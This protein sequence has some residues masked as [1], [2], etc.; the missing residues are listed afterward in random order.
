MLLSNDSIWKKK[1]E[2]LLGL[3]QPYQV[4]KDNT[5]AFMDIDRFSYSSMLE[6]IFPIECVFNLAFIS[7][8]R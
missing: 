1:A 8:Q 7:R 5:F 3:A 4:S 6:D 2:F